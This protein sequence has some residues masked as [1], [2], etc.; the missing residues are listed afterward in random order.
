MI[1]EAMQYIVNLAKPELTE[2]DGA[3]FCHKKLTE[4]KR[5]RGEAAEFEDLVGFIEYCNN[6]SDSDEERIYVQDYKTVVLARR[7]PYGR[8]DITARA[9]CKEPRFRFGAKMHQETAMMNLLTQFEKIPDGLLDLVCNVKASSEIQSEDN[10][11]TQ[12]VSITKG[13]HLGKKVELKNPMILTPYSTF[14]EIPQ[15]D[16]TC[17]FRV[18]GEGS[19]HPTFSITESESHEY[20]FTAMERIRVVLK[21]EIKDLKIY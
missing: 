6:D 5:E 15:P 7:D 11:I 14:R 9:T 16:V 10:G 8:L 3:S 17:V 1:E 2:I 20:K 4:V 18:H 12:Q 19:E 13:N 21:K